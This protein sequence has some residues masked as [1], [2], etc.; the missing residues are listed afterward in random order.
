MVEEDIATSKVFI[1][2]PDLI[3]NIAEILQSDDPNTYVI[4]IY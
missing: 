2:E 4:F 1:Y 3:S